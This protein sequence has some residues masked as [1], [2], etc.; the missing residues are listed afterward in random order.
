MENKEKIK[1]VGIIPA[2]LASTRLPDKP[3]VD[4]CG[5]SL[6][7]H[8]WESVSSSLLMDRIVIAVDNELVAE[9]CLKMGAKYIMTPPSLPSGTDRVAYTCK[10]IGLNY[11]IIV[12]I[13]GDEPF[14]TGEIIDD[15][16][17]KF[18]AT[19]ADV[20]T[21]IKKINS[22]EELDDKSVVKV[23]LRKDGTAMYFSRS[24]I[25]FIRD[26]KPSDKINDFVFWKHIGIYAYRREAL[27]TFTELPVSKL[28]QAEKLE[29]L[30][31]MEN[32]AK[33]YCVETSAD[34]I[35]IDTKEDLERVRK[36]IQ[37]KI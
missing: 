19:N 28:E 16:I 8:V 14:L 24:A 20:G 25:P 32:G 31:L 36:I 17:V 1:A 29:Q 2:R 34:L 13:Q 27:Q 23:V 9:Q 7:Q 5:K 11:D 6:I 15:L 26:A 18:A 30:R 3:L 10:A 12:N 33:Y 4:I 35:G 37:N 21:L 22:T